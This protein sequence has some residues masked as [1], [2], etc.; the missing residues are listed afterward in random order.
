MGTE[1]ARAAAEMLDMQGLCIAMNVDP[2]LMVSEEE[3]RQA[4]ERI[5][6]LTGLGVVHTY[7]NVTD[8]R[9]WFRDGSGELKGNIPITIKGEKILTI[10]QK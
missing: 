4:E 3:A 7:Y 9:G 8:Y 10:T 1:H 2:E 5:E 6:D